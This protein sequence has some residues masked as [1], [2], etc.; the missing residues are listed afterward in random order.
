M[1]F[2]PLNGFVLVS[3][4][5]GHQHYSIATLAVSASK[6][7]L[8]HL[9]LVGQ[10]TG[11]GQEGTALP[12]IFHFDETGDEMVGCKENSREQIAVLQF[13]VQSGF[14]SDAS[15]DEKKGSFVAAH[16]PGLNDD[17][18][19]DK[20]GDISVSRAV[21][22]AP[23]SQEPPPFSSDTETSFDKS[24]PCSTDHQVGPG[25]VVADKPNTAS[26]PGLEECTTGTP[27]NSMRPALCRPVQ[28]LETDGVVSENRPNRTD[29]LGGSNEAS[30]STGRGPETGSAINQLDGFVDGASNTS[31]TVDLPAEKSTAE[32]DAA[33]GAMD[34]VAAGCA[35][36]PVSNDED[37]WYEGNGISQ[38]Q[39]D[40]LRSEDGKRCDSCLACTRERC[41]RCS[42]C[43]FDGITDDACVFRCCEN[44]TVE[45]KHL[46]ANDI[47]TMRSC[48]ERCLSEGSLVQCK[49]KRKGVSCS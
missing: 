20:G 45:T 36:T 40:G 24:A 8:G 15:D 32:G 17:G 31:A 29:V 14:I 9:E 3:W 7:N 16:V 23:S 11:G 22:N 4:N 19:E 49:I 42:L 10:F 21:S 35:D 5:D 41:R 2:H 1:W 12:H 37:S 39:A 27:S 18:D 34:T 26:H 44:N 48:E 6:P 28:A 47:G 13:D 46:F 30:H 43:R 38:E 25:P 33:T